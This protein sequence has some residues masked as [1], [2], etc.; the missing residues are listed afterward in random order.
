MSSVTTT[1]R[2]APAKE[3]SLSP[4]PGAR[5]LTRFKSDERGNVAMTFGLMIFMMVGFIGASVDIGRWMLARKQTQEAIDAAVLA[6]LRKYQESSDTGLAISAAQINYNYVVTKNGRGLVGQN[7]MI[8]SDTIAFVLQNGNRK[9]TATGDVVIKT[10][11]IGIA[12]NAISKG[13]SKIGTLPV[14]KTDGSENAV[15]EIAQG[16]NAGTNLEIS[17]MIDITGSMGESDNSGSTKIA[18]VK[19]AAKN[20]VDILVWADQ[21]TYTSKIA[22]VPFS[23]T[24]NLGTPSV[25]TKARGNFQAGASSNTPGSQYYKVNGTN[26]PISN[27]CVTERIGNHEY[28]DESPDLYPVGRYY[29]TYGT[30]QGTGK[31]PTATP[32]MP[33]SN[34]KTAL[35]SVI[36]SLSAG[37]TTAGHIGTAWAWYMLSPNFNSIW[38]SNAGVARP[39]S[40]LTALTA[41]GRPVLRKI[42]V[43]MTDG[44]YNTE[45]C[46]GVTDW[47]RSCTPNNGSAVNQALSLCAG[48]KAKGIE[49]YTI[50]AQVSNAAK[51]M[52]KQCATDPAHFYDATDGTKMQQAFMDIAYKL[53][54]PYISH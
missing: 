16:G 44:D 1:R 43:L 14:L 18:T 30:S 2:V 49:V 31:C 54:P 17:V 50:G 28:D 51:T 32:I 10:P 34:D 21:S 6:G 33:L 48:M 24:V 4:I 15:S 41:K 27:V 23:E 13:V 36:T 42:A 7:P 9:M 46:N 52:L 47:Y 38:T 45:Y 12:T 39:Y 26:L 37:G 29:S 35:R 11:F 5:T 3:G 20:M 22:I 40:D 8:T 53:V 25:A 19:T